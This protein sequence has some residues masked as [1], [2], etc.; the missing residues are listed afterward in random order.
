MST[1]NRKIL[2][3]VLMYSFA[4]VLEDYIAKK[5]K[6]TCYGCEIEHPSQKEHDCMMMT[7]QEHLDRHFENAFNDFTMLDVLLVFKDRVKL[8]NI[9]PETV[10]NYFLL[11][12]IMLD[13]LHSHSYKG[14][15]YAL[16]KKNISKSSL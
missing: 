5:K 2:Q 8:V 11:N 10:C 6:S 15:V 14:S 3:T 7:E 9:R 12:V 16:L 4:A 13:K 1:L